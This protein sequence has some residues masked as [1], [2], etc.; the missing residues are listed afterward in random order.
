VR[1]PARKQRDTSTVWFLVGE[2]NEM[3]KQWCRRVWRPV[4]ASDNGLLNRP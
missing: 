4:N 3:W 2:A 1:Q